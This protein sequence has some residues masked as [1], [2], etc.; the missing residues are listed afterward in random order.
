MWRRARRAVPPP[1]RG[2]ARRATAARGTWLP[3]RGT[4]GLAPA[5]RARRLASAQLLDAI[6]RAA[7][8]IAGL[9]AALPAVPPA[10]LFD[11]P[12]AQAAYVAAEAIADRLAGQ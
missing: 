5:A 8:S 6:E 2:W 3:A 1:S 9:P 7:I 10:A 4:G 11:D 12:G